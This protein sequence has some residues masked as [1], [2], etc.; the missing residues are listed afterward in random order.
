MIKPDFSG[1]RFYNVDIDKQ[2]EVND[3]AYHTRDSHLARYELAKGLLG[4]NDTVLDIA[5]GSGYGTEMLSWK[6]KRVYGIDVAEQAIEYAKEYH[7]Q[8]NIEYQVAE[9]EDFEIG[10]KVDT[11]TCFETIE[12]VESPIRCLENTLRFLKP[13]GLFILSTPVKD[14]G[15]KFHI[16]L[17]N[18][19]D[20][21]KLV[22]KYF[23]S[24]LLLYQNGKTFGFDPPKRVFI[25]LAICR[26]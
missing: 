26:K 14:D 22:N 7:Q 3:H 24:S 2:M 5:C 23:R 11:I 12:H 4:L 21:A 25:K 6:A 9:M 20:L 19:E 16:S 1:E 17:L 8:K 10:E 18:E 13:N 15:N